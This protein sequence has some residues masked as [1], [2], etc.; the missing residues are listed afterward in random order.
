MNYSIT[1]SSATWQPR[2][3]CYRS[4]VFFRNL[5]LTELSFSQEKKK[6]SGSAWKMLLIQYLYF[7]GAFVELRKANISFFTSVFLSVSLS[8]R[9]NSA[10]TERIFMKIHFCGFFSKSFFF[11]FFFFVRLWDKVEKIWS[12]Q[13]ADYNI[14][15]RKSFACWMTKATN[16]HSECFTLTAFPRQQWL[17]ESASM[18]P[19]YV[20]DLY[21]KL[22]KMGS[23]YVKSL[24]DKS[25]FMA[26]Q[27]EVW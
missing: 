19:F 21:L 25:C 23:T 14:L 4:A 24:A 3:L 27:K 8:S 11:F 12:T 7:S 6:S 17:Q 10:S 22:C 18:I 15:R 20:H 2:P 26:R 9:N 13:A 1:W 5:R 16:T